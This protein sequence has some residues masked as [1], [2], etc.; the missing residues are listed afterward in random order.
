MLKS[1]CSIYNACCFVFVCLVFFSFLKEFLRINQLSQVCNNVWKSHYDNIYLSLSSDLWRVWP[2]NRVLQVFLA[3]GATVCLNTACALVYRKTPIWLQP[4]QTH[5]WPLGFFKWKILQDLFAE[6][7]KEEEEE[8]E[9]GLYSI[10]MSND[11][12]D[13]VVKDCRLH[14]PEPSPF[15][16]L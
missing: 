3:S 12:Q 13:S 14:V 4:T 16:N 11:R 15:L 8:E 10:P 1:H 2:L 7:K 5:R 6:P 9:Q